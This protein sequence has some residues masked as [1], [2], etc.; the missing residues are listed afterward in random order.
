MKQEQG[1]EIKTLK[2]NKIQNFIG[3]NLTGLVKF[4]NIGLQKI[5]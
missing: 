5:Q 1:Q 2:I 4:T 3:E